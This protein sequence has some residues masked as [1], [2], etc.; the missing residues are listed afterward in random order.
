MKKKKN[1]IAEW[2]QFQITKEDILRSFDNWTFTKG[3][4]YFYQK[5]V[6]SM[7]LNDH[8]VEGKVAGSSKSAYDV[9]L[10]KDGEKLRGVCSCPVGID[11]KHCVA[12]ALQWAIIP[13][14]PGSL[15]NKHNPIDH[16]ADDDLF[17]EN[18]NFDDNEDLDED[19]Y[20]N[21]VEDYD[22]DVNYFHDEDDS[23]EED[24]YD[25]DED[26]DSETAQELPPYANLLKIPAQ[27]TFSDCTDSEISIQ[28][29]S[30]QDLSNL[31]QFFMPAIT[32]DPNISFFCQDFI[33][34]SWKFIFEKLDEEFPK[35]EIRK[36][37]ENLQL[38][39]HD[40]QNLNLFSPIS[41]LNR[42]KEEKLQKICLK[43]WFSGYVSLI[44][45]IKTEFKERGLFGSEEEELYEYYKNLE[46]DRQED[47]LKE[48]RRDRYDSGDRDWHD[49][50]DELEPYED[51]DLD[52]STLNAY[53]NYFFRWIAEPIKEIC[54]YILMLNRNNMENHA[55]FLMKEGISWLIHFNVPKDCLVPTNEIEALQDL[56]TIIISKTT[57]LSTNFS[58]PSEKLDFL[59]SLFKN[60]S[61]AEIA[62]LVQTQ[63]RI[64]DN[65]DKNIPYLI[66]KLWADYT[67]EPNVPKYKL[68]NHL[69]HQ[70][71]PIKIQP[72]IELL[73]QK[74]SLSPDTHEIEIAIQ[75][76]LEKQPSSYVLKI[77]NLFLQQAQK[78]P[79]NNYEDKHELYIRLV[80]WF[81]N[82]FE[83]NKEYD[84]AFNILAEMVQRHPN[85]ISFNHYKKLK[86]LSTL[87]EISLQKIYPSL[88]Q[89]LLNHGVKD[90]QFRINLDLEQYD[91]ACDIIPHLSKD[92]YYADHSHN[93][94]WNSIMSLLPYLPSISDDNK[95][96]ML[97]IL[98]KLIAGWIETKTSH[99]P[100]ASIAE[101]VEQ[102]HI[103]SLSLSFKNG[104]KL[105][106]TWFKSFA[107]NHYRLH[108]LRAALARK[109]LDLKK[110]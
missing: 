84:S 32:H 6:K 99:R 11:C 43:N 8:R 31:I 74:F 10:R 41:I 63:A 9:K 102:I 38:D 3:N 2:N 95:E 88:V 71:L 64:I 69:I 83:F 94:Q 13:I 101:V 52:S 12:L 26:D 108:N 15:S 50:D 66:E 68:L 49:Y 103:I 45:I 44:N 105:W 109:G 21:D 4:E 42:I 81:E 33:D 96:V 104:T 107:N 61:S 91:Q 37:K 29:L 24:A 40:E 86:K 82:Y 62:Q 5:M 27:L 25:N 100:D 47:D 20:E 65:P 57:I 77:Q 90:L 110:S 106:D 48:S 58:S 80:N 97:Q 87:V 28:S 72:F 23:D 7:K 16:E 75:K 30:H 67:A 34:H 36:P 55:T 78:L 18:D 85:Y 53:L 1:Q 93:S 79:K 39:N 46:Y 22:N 51:F 54:D 35:S 98:K 60:N 73:I 59:F 19:D 92:S 17:P 14:K 89:E 76:L 56:K 70:Y